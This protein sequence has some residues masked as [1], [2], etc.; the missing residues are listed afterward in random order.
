LYSTKKLAENVYG[1]GTE[2]SEKYEGQR[3]K[4]H[5]SSV[6]VSCDVGKTGVH[7]LGNRKTNE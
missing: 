7:A 5:D 3:M 6:T 2:T 1:F 4:L